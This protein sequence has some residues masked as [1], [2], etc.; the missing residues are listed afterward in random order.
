MRYPLV[1]PDHP[2]VD[3]VL[4]AA[5]QYSLPVN[6]LSWGRVEQ[7]GPLAARNP[8]MR[9]VIDHLGLLQPCEP[10]KPRPHPR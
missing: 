2:S 6:V 8:N 7:L 9:I 10:P 5:A 3:R 1:A 4:A